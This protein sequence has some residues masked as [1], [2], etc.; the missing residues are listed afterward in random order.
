MDSRERRVSVSV[1]AAGGCHCIRMALEE[2]LSKG[3]A[4]MFFH[5]H[6]ADGGHGS[7]E[8]SDQGDRV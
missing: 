8:H 1:M 5:F 2:S 3:A 6:K 4:D 7:Y